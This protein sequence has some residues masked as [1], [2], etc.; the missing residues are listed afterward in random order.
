MMIK[1]RNL[2]SDIF[3]VLFFLIL[4]S[5]GAQACRFNV[6]EV[7][8]VYFPEDAYYLYGFVR[9][10]TPAAQVTAFDEVAKSVLAQSNIVFELIQIDKQKE[11]PALPHLPMKQIQSYPALVL[12]SPSP[13]NRMRIL[14]IPQNAQPFSQRLQSV[15]ENLIISPKR[16]EILKHVAEIYGFVLLFEGRDQEQNKQAAKAADEVIKEITEM[17]PFMPQPVYAP[18]P[19]N[20]G[21]L[22]IDI[23]LKEAQQEET[24]LWSLD[25]LDRDPNIPHAVVMHGRG[26]IVGV[27]LAGADIDAYAL[28]Y[29]L[30]VIGAD[31]ECGL[32]RRWMTGRMIP[33]RWDESVKTRIARVLGYDPENPMIMMEVARIVRRGYYP[34]GFAD[35]PKA[36]DSQ[37]L[38][39]QEIP[40]VIEDEPN[41]TQ[42]VTME[43][44]TTTE[45]TEPT[46]PT[47][48]TQD[49][50][51]KPK[52]KPAKLDM[53]MDPIPRQSPAPKTQM[54]SENDDTESS[55]V[56]MYRVPLVLGAI[57]VSGIL[58]GGVII[59]L[60]NRGRAA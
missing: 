26:R 49:E 44:T 30:S 1:I 51:D 11:H 7:G 15:L 48:S 41:R 34:G 14:P 23:S 22:R 32:D 4:L 17:L 50:S 45:T 27:P 24:L 31:C 36:A 55:F 53:P 46:Q 40:I 47:T 21:P 43:V 3:K 52:S 42:P 28:G 60:R 10:D 5:P 12:V 59:G 35:F 56:S 33:L 25:L 8:Y 20:K 19:L 13:E 6:R 9:D 54:G 38:G 29:F 57:V 58:I 16:N 18:A 2:A 39:Y 37:I